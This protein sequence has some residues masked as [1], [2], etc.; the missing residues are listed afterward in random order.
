MLTRFMIGEGGAKP[1]L[2]SAYSVHRVVVARI[3]QDQERS[4]ICHLQAS[5]IM[6]EFCAASDGI[7]P[8][9][10]SLHTLK[11][12]FDY[13]LKYCFVDN[14][15]PAPSCRAAESNIL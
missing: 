3:A 4:V 14:H 10:V 15:R 12:P 13:L 7:G 5:V 1:L 6:Y 8:L 11:R 2:G 9:L